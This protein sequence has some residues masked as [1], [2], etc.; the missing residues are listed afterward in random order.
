MKHHLTIQ[1][2]DNL[3]AFLARC[4]IKGN[5]AEAL[6]E[7]K[8][9]INATK[10]ELIRIANAAELSKEANPAKPDEEPPIDEPLPEL[11]GIEGGKGKAKK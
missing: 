8:Y 10:Q 11:E 3:F 7:A 5:E 1:S 9:Q 4:D 6:V 2:C